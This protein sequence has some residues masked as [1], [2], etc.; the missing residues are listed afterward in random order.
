MEV[1]EMR[2][3][4]HFMWTERCDDN[5]TWFAPGS[6]MAGEFALGGAEFLFSDNPEVLT[7]VQ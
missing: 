2:E 3:A 6:H 7:T 4:G 1:G 5:D